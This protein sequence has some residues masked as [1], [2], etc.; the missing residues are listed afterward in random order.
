[1]PRLVALI[2]VFASAM[3]LDIAIASAGQKDQEGYLSD[4]IST[5]QKERLSEQRYWHLLLHYKRTIYGSYE[6]EEDGPD[7]FNSPAGKTNPEAELIATL[8]SF[9]TS[10]DE[11]KSGQE[12]P[13][14][15]FPARY[16]WLKSRLDFDPARMQEQRCPRLEKWLGEVDPARITLVFASSYLNNPASMFGH[17]FLRIDKKR[18]GSRQKL[19]DYG[20]NYAAIA[21]TGNPL[22]Y[23][24]KG[25]VGGFKGTFSVFPYYVKV[26][27]Y[28]NLESRDLWEY[29]LNFNEDQ[30]NYFLLHLWELGGNYFDYYYF[31][32]NCSYH[33]LS[34]LEV[35]DP[36]LHLTDSFV[37]QVIPGDTVKAITRYPALISKVVYRPSL[38]S[39]MNN[40][41]IR[42]SDRE[43]AIFYQLVDDP[44]VIEKKEYIDLTVP[45]RVLILD[46]YLDYAQYRDLKRT[47][48]ASAIDPTTR[49]ILLARSQLDYRDEDRETLR[50]SS[51]PELG[52]GSARVGLGYGRNGQ[53]MFEQISIRPA[54]QDLLAD[55]MGY[56]KGSQILFLGLTA[57]YYN[58][59]QKTKID[60]FKIIDIVSLTPYDPLFRK[61]S[62]ALSFNVENLRDLDC[63]YCDSFNSKYGLGLAYRPDYFSPVLF[64]GLANIE[65]QLSTHLDRDYRLGG[66][67]TVGALVD[68]PRNWR[69]QVVGNYMSFTFGDQSHF[70]KT[71]VSPRY[72]IS[73]NLDV[74][75]DWNVVNSKQEWSFGLN[76]YF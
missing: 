62:W 12:H 74:R 36:N 15:V 4:L 22:I 48:S 10:P 13:Q 53:E 42:M 33:I 21:D 3:I 63:G 61:K 31:Q 66:G 57:R 46:A 39:Q 32:E 11:L 28:N 59:S 38:L 72:T 64:Y 20:V 37:F 47:D 51:P 30:M 27:E 24:Y 19:L 14:C 43:R 67:G 45:A 1:M 7:F 2:L 16:K 29:E 75:A 9:F 55:D 56:A 34:L 26:Q 25:L 23:T 50:F 40:K 60:S 35:A 76:Y 5:A 65:L 68:L 17:T 8:T 52:H 44:T 49:R 41:R 73:Q 58:E 6:S 71:E 70:Y 69:I 18:E 54:Y